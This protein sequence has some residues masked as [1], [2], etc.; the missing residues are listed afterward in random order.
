MQI[1]PQ[2][3]LAILGMALVTY[4]MRI[5]GLWLMSRVTL[6]GRIKTW[7]GYLP[8]AVIVAI[9]APTVL[10]SGLTETGAALATVLVAARTRNVLLSMVI[11]VGVVFGLRM[12]LASLR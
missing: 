3:L 7:L 9:V 5:G 12:L 1:N 4:L 8:G 11:G 6:S 10:S 2:V